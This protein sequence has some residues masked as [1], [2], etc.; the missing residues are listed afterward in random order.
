MNQKSFVIAALLSS[1]EGVH[2]N[3]IDST[4]LIDIESEVQQ[5][6]NAGVKRFTDGKSNS[7]VAFKNAN[8][9]KGQW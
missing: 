1:V 7:W 4:K 6:C 9:M 2:I 3:S 8:H 5:G